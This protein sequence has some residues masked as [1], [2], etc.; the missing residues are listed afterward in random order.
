[1]TV[2]PR[3]TVRAKVRD[4]AMFCGLAAGA[5]FPTLRAIA[6]QIIPAVIAETRRIATTRYTDPKDPR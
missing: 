2:R 6:Q 5:I 4:V 3:Y 1:M